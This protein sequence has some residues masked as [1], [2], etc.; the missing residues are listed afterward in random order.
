MA[1]AYV[2]KSKMLNSFQLISIILNY[3]QFISIQ[4]IQNIQKL[5]LGLLLLERSFHF[6]T[7]GQKIT[8]LA[9]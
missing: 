5:R 6:G 2:S 7:R 8:D 9:N 3:S 4:C 1:F